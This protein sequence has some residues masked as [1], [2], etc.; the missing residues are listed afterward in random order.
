M[1]PACFA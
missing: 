1:G